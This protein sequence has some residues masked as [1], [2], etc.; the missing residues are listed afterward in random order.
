[1][2]IYVVRTSYINV[3][4]R[5]IEMKP[6]GINTMTESQGLVRLRADL[7]NDVKELHTKNDATLKLIYDKLDE[8]SALNT[9]SHNC[10]Q[11]Q[12]TALSLETKI[13]NAT[14]GVKVAGFVAILS[15][16]VAGFASA[17]WHKLL[18]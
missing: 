5:D 6:K 7:R 17:A 4:Q 2:L 16:A 9:K 13:K 12:L 3:S 15:I 11:Q 14:I 18:T 1:M 10:L 8:F